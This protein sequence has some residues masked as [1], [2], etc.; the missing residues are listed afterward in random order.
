MVGLGSVTTKRGGAFA[1]RVFWSLASTSSLCRSQCQ[2]RH[3]Q[4]GWLPFDFGPETGWRLSGSGW[5]ACKNN[6]PPTFIG[7]SFFCKYSP[8]S[9]SLFR[10]M[11]VQ[12]R[13]SFFD[14]RF[15]HPERCFFFFFFFSGDPRILG[16]VPWF[17]IGPM[18]RAADLWDGYCKTLAC[19]LEGK[20]SNGFI[21]I[22]II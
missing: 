21:I 7:Q 6:H 8:C 22:Y 9:T 17:E 4:G 15:L 18:W 5:P 2:C 12:V 14:N 13:Y 11:M 20:S 1:N 19:K 10:H 3:R 16:P